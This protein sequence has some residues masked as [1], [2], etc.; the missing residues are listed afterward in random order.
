LID[1]Y[2]QLKRFVY[3]HLPEKFHMEGDQRVDVRDIVF[4]EVIGNA[5]VHREYTNPMATELVITENEVTITNP[6]R[7]HFH[8]PIDPSSFNPFPKNPN[9]RKF[10]TAFGWTDEVGSGIRNTTKW[11]PRYVPGAKPLF[12]EDDVFKTIIPLKF[13]HLG[14]YT[15]KWVAWLDLPEKAEEQVRPGFKETALVPELDGASWKEVILHLVPSWDRKGTKLERLDW[16]SKQVSD[17]ES[18]KQVPSWDRKGTKVL[19]K[20]VRYLIQILTLTARP[21]SLDELME[22]IGYKNRSTFR[23]NY[24][25]PLEEVGWVEKTIP[26]KPQSPDQQY[27]ITE[28]GRLFLA[29]RNLESE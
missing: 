23:G 18:I 19:H 10:F 1:T 28:Q 20:K 12:I 15:N 7:A 9:I 2:Q 3:K 17:P 27:V 24:L 6:N 4:R 8:G 26:D 25:N 22:F 29:G 11:L 21:I 13:V 14:T 5:V 16:P